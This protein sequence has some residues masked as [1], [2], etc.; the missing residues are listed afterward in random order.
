MI[1]I[2][3]LCFICTVHVCA[4]RLERRASMAFRSTSINFANRVL[5]Q[6]VDH[7]LLSIKLTQQNCAIFQ[8]ECT[9]NVTKT[10]AATNNTTTTTTTNNNNNSYYNNNNN[11]NNTHC[12]VVPF[13]FFL[14]SGGTHVNLLQL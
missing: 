3:P 5:H 2:K 11:N 1:I 14:D 8:I 12:N 6:I 7:N 4:Q 9:V 10:A 13:F